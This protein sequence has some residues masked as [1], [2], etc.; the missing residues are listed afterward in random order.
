MSRRHFLKEIFNMDYVQLK[1]MYVKYG[2]IK[3]VAD[4]LGVTDRTV[5]NWFREGDI[6][7]MKHDTRKRPPEKQDAL[8]RWIRNNRGVKLPRSP[9]KI[10]A[11]T[12][13]PII[14][15]KSFFTRRRKKWMKWASKFP[16]LGTINVTLRAVD[17]TYVPTRSI[18]EYF[19]KVDP[20]LLRFSITGRRKTGSLFKVVL[21]PKE[22]D[23]LFNNDVAPMLDHDEQERQ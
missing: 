2:T 16:N 21:S 7:G 9:T 6:H 10:S 11:I 22:L 4:K 19:F 20:Y 12:G 14:S 3:A 5:K 15:I 8:L 18:D 13:I 1:E 17:G 23:A